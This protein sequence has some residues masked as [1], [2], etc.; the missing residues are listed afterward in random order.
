MILEKRLELKKVPLIPQCSAEEWEGYREQYRKTLLTEEYGR[1]VPEPEDLFFEE[2]RVT[3]PNFC[4]GFGVRY[5]V[6]AHVTVCGRS[7]HFPFTV[8]LPTTEGPH[9]FVVFNDFAAGEPT[10]SLPIEELIQSG[11]AI[12]HLFY[13]DITTDDD[14]FTTGLAGAVY[15]DGGKNRTGDDSGK[16]MMWA[17]ANMRVMDYA[18]T[19]SCLDHK[20]G[21]VAGHSRLGK[22]ALVTGMLDERFRYVI[23]NNAGCSGDGL[24]RGR[25]SGERI[26]DIVKRF[27]YWFCPNFMKY[28]E[29][30]KYSFP[31]DQHM[32]LATI[33]PRYLL[34]GAAAEDAWA[35]PISQYQCCFAA[36]QAWKNVGR[37][38]LVSPDRNAEAGENF[39]EGSICFHMRPG[40]H[41]MSRIDWNIYLATIRKKMKLDR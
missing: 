24:F 1:P 25:D 30:K 6:T 23:S 34:V 35:D 37:V 18:M 31:G 27:P 36:S 16:I 20:N 7:F 10:R 29:Y 4:A 11:F 41:I 8:C 40:R 3:D 28:A 32:L 14:D 26:P 21:A 39:D 5:P 33:A 17:W 38:G 15:P 9:P 2:G 13:Q 22:T 19:L 12:L